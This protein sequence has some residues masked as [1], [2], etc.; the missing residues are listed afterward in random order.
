MPAALPERDRPRSQRV[1]LQ[2]RCGNIPAPTRVRRCCGRGRPRSRAAGGGLHAAPVRSAGG[3]AAGLVGRGVLTAPPGH[4]HGP[5]A[6]WGQTRPTREG[7][8]SAAFRPL[9]RA[10]VTPRPHPH[11]RPTLKRPKGRAPVLREVPL[12]PPRCGAREEESRAGRARCP[13]RAAG[14]FAQCGGALGP[15]APYPARGLQA[16]SACER[17]SVSHPRG[18]PTLKRRERRAPGVGA[19]VGRSSPRHRSVRT[20][21]AA[22]GTAASYHNGFPS[23]L[24]LSRRGLVDSVP[25]GRKT[26]DEGLK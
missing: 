14:A 3:G 19:L 8:R 16:A 21:R 9:Q 23:Y 22:L 24:I 1:R 2:A 18:R 10:N 20:V 15:D 7:S 6:R 25:G 11:C 17:H 26:A 5:A 13:H 4:P 12:T